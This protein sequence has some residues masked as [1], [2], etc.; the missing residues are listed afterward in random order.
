MQK[1]KIYII[2]FAFISLSVLGAVLPI[3]AHAATCTDSDGTVV[4]ET[5]VLGV[6]C[7][8]AAEGRELIWDILAIAVNFL[9]A[10]VGLAVVA[11]IVFGAVTYATAAGSADQ[12]KK[13]IG[14][15]TN[16]VIALLLFIFMYAI[17]NFL[18]PGGLF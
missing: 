4:V 16:A 9:A 18:V 17:I 10:G 7:A 13:G 1:I 5:S 3:A 6:D 2:A 14:Y 15:I 8:K 12:A 11:G